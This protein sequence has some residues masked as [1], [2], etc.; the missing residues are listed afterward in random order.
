MTKEPAEDDRNARAIARLL[1]D[2]PGM[3]PAE[4]FVA[5]ASKVAEAIC[6][7]VLRR[8][9][10]TY[11]DQCGLHAL[12]NR[13]NSVPPATVCIERHLKTI[14][15]W[16]NIAAH[17][18]G[19]VHQRHPVVDD[20]SAGIVALS[21]SALEHWYFGDYLQ[22][23]AHRRLPQWLSDA[24]ASTLRPT[25][26]EGAVDSK[27][28][29]SG[30]HNSRPILGRPVDRVKNRTA[31]KLLFQT[32][33]FSGEEHAVCRPLLAWQE[34]LP[35][36]VSVHGKLAEKYR[37]DKMIAT[38]G[39][40]LREQVH[41]RS[42]SGFRALLQRF[43]VG[44]ESHHR[45]G[46]YHHLEGPHVGRTYFTTGGIGVAYKE[47][48]AERSQLGLPV[49]DERET[50]TGAVSHFEFGEILWDKETGAKTVV[51]YR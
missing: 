12:A 23:P 34:G 20:W 25:V 51:Q 36:A 41:V 43:T 37:Q 29:E 19:E 32:Q 26:G 24:F 22:R 33:D 45:R 10:V 18:K 46:L 13:L 38:L 44:P 50:K 9:G 49:A 21:L 48:G 11:D 42:L 8:E 2:M 3:H 30:F 1:A 15:A 39:C 35:K 6:K 4:H 28:F 5:E 16:R 17:D 7:T 31:Y 47:L 27:P 40:P 14:A